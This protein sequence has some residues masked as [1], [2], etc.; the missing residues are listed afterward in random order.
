M[1]C[2]RYFTS[3]KV[4]STGLAALPFF[5]GTGCLEASSFFSR[6]RHW[7]LR[8]N[9]FINGT[10]IRRRSRR[11]GILQRFSIVSTARR[12]G[13]AGAVDGHPKAVE[14]VLR[15]GHVVRVETNQI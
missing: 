10:R 12:N 1:R 15:Q 4:C 2:F 14:A 3:S 8:S 7:F 13:V 11:R 9:G 6:G 5:S